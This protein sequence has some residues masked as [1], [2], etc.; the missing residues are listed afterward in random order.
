MITR[1]LAAPKGAHIMMTREKWTALAAR[2]AST[3]DIK[4][5]EDML[6]F[7]TG[8]T[9]NGKHVSLDDVFIDHLKVA[10]DEILSLRAFM[11]PLVI[12]SRRPKSG[13]C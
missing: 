8:F 13:K 4:A 6:V 12:A 5:L 1:A 11:S 9:L 3:S 7:G 2:I 10:E